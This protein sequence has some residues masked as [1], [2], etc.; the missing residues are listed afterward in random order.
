MKNSRTNKI[1]N[2]LKKTIILS[3]IL[4]M[5]IVFAFTL[6]YNYKLEEQVRERDNMI[7]KLTISDQLVKE[8]FD[9]KHDSIG[10]TTSYILK[11]SKRII[12]TVNTEKTIYTPET[13]IRDDKL[14]YNTYNNLIGKYNNLVKDFNTLST[15]YY[16]TRD[17]LETNKIIIS[18][19]KKE[20]PIH[21]SIEKKQGVRKIS[22][23]SVKLDSALLLL[24]YYG[25]RLKYNAKDKSWKIALPSK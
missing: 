15:N 21:T 12:R 14:L 10:G 1:Q 17:S 2:I 8:Y 7:S 16:N 6:Y 11:E 23:N 22:I 19:I 25:D 24:P 20:Y 4:G 3:F 18:L 5:G 9:I 13:I